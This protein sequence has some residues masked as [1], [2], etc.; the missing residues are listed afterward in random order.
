[1]AGAQ[2]Q[3]KKSDVKEF[4]FS[5]EGKDKKGKKIKGELRVASE[6]VARVQLRNKGIEVLKIKKQT[7]K[8]GKKITGQDITMFT[9]QLAT[10][11]KSGVPLLQSF[12]IVGQGHA[13][14][15]VGKL[16]LDIKASIETGASLSAAF[17]E[18]PKYFDDLY[19]R[20][21][22]YLPRKNTGN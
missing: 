10:M 8:R 5:W 4:L 3:K 11:M 18:H 16:V 20:S 21:L 15:A 7:F 2:P 6:S 12:D 22:G 17:R 19:F 1:M 13:N 9:R 14:P